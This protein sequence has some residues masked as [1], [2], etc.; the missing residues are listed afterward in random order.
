MIK[1][2][3][4]YHDISSPKKRM[5]GIAFKLLVLVL[6]FATAFENYPLFHILA[7]LFSVIIAITFFVITWNSRRFF[8]NHFLLFI[9]ISFLF[10]GILDLIHA[11]GYKGMMIFERK[12]ANLAT[13]I[14]IATRFLES[15]SF[16]GAFL[17]IR[18]KVVPELLMA[19][20]GIITTLLLLSIFEWNL[21]PDC[22]VE[23][24]GLTPFKIY[25]EYGVSLLL[26]VGMLLLHHHRDR[27]NK[28]VL[29]Y[30]HWAM[31]ITICAELCFTSYLHAYGVSN[32]LGHVFKIIAFYLL[33]KAVVE[34]SLKTP[35]QTLYHNILLGQ[36]A[37]ESANQA[38]IHQN[39]QLEMVQTVAHLGHWFWEIK[40]DRFVLS[41]EAYHILAIDPAIA[42]PTVEMIHNHIPD[43]Y[44]QQVIEQLEQVLTGNA[45]HFQT[46]HPVRHADG[47]LT[48]VFAR[49]EVIWESGVAVKMIGTVL[50]VTEQKLREQEL[51]E[52][53]LKLRT[54]LEEREK[55]LQC[56]EQAN[57]AKSD[58][59][60]NMSHEIR[61]PLNAI[62][63][64]SYLILQTPLTSKQS[65]YL[66]KIESA[67]RTLLGVIN[68][69]LDYSKIE[70]GHLV[71]DHVAFQLDDVISNVANIAIARK[72]DKD[73][74]LLYHVTPSTP[75]QMMGDP[76]R[77]GAVL[78]NLTN[79]AIKFTEHGEV[80][81]RVDAKQQREQHY[82]LHFS[83]QDTGI[84]ISAEQQKRLFQS[85]SQADSSIS[86]RYG[87]TGL[88]LA[89]SKKL[90]E[91]MGGTLSLQSVV[92]Q[93][94]TFE[95]TIPLQA[96]EIK[97]DEVPSATSLNGVRVLVV[98]DNATAREILEEQLNAFHMEV[99]SVAS[100]E[101]ALDVLHHEPRPELILLDD[102]MT[103]LSGVET[104]RRLRGQINLARIPEVL[105]LSDHGREKV[106]QEAEAL[107]ITHFMCKPISP[108]VLLETLLEVRGECLPRKQRSRRPL[109]HPELR[110]GLSAIAGARVLLVEDNAI[111]QE[112]AIELLG[113]AG[114]AVTPAAS[115][116]SALDLLNSE[117]PFDLVLMDIQMSDMDG[118]ATTR[119]LRQDPR[120]KTLP[121]V[122]MTAHA[123][124]S[125]REKALQLGMQDHI[126]KPIEPE[127]LFAALVQ[128][129]KPRQAN[130]QPLNLS[131][132]A[133]R[134][135]EEMVLPELTGV[136]VQAGLARVGGN[137]ELLRKLLVRFAQEN[138]AITQKISNL[139]TENPAQAGELIHS[140]KGVAGNLGMP[141]VAKSARAVE[142]ALKG[143]ES[144]DAALHGLTRVLDPILKGL[145]KL[146]TTLEE[147]YSEA[148]PLEPARV[149]SRIEEMSAMLEQD[150]AVAQHVQGQLQTLL[151]Q[152]R[153]AHKFQ[154]VVAAMD[155]FDTDRV[156]A[157][158]TEIAGQL[159][160]PA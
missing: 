86:R 12:D 94:T 106:R 144:L 87:G 134:P 14:W 20:Y 102:Q 136:D 62:I 146:D 25:S 120:F 110:D 47:R 131:P 137:A 127:Q 55:A 4:A 74:D 50:D 52:G 70:A 32:L 90:V 60:A 35:F 8:D 53:K 155:E 34:T 130:Q 84:G 11:L 39:I 143:S 159:S 72:E 150:F 64:L 61:T 44:K 147:A 114:V 76:M 91:L 57:L 99:C 81:I 67:G 128:W 96:V 68:D 36:E 31:L 123:M 160:Q 142:L 92:G 65:N 58:F 29:G 9:G 115:G 124:V 71:L 26:V 18:R 133:P 157:L 140:F 7:E 40:P 54:A 141:Q 145:S 151:Q 56:A 111:N 88:G 79:N 73:L 24:Q 5:A 117:A 41:T 27:F 3:T 116:Q 33:Y 45:V 132:Q 80:V 103:G 19:L 125:D 105:M 22:L 48:H 121:V 97:P 107:G 152:S 75:T 119:Q 108:S 46:E 158:L 59:L 126:P 153:Y 138:S 98:D 1:E 82:L 154:Q 51:D 85:F 101:A 129:I 109:I 38:L 95:F 43:P 100:G 83:V 21:F 139:A 104:V 10:V 93:G 2:L 66:E 149:L 16:L 148:Q 77:L 113:Y 78:I 6:L 28:S 23:G 69:I 118:Y 13:Q 15:F 17:F 30:L 112:I 156:Q 37:L 135:L 42:Q 89:I 49:A 122:A 63:N